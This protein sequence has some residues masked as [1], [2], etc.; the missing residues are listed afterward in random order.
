MTDKNSDNQRE[1]KDGSFGFMAVFIFALAMGVM[2]WVTSNHKEKELGTKAP[3]YMGCEKYILTPAEI[4]AISGH[5]FLDNGEIT[6]SGKYSYVE[7]NRLCHIAYDSDMGNR[8]VFSHEYGQANCADADYDA[9]QPSGC[10]IQRV[11]A[12]RVLRYSVRSSYTMVNGIT[13]YF[14][15][16]QN[17]SSEKARCAEEFILENKVVLKR[18]LFRPKN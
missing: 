4:S 3:C 6:V 12:N 2:Y 18:M 9:V 17:S 8:S 5:E 15:V 14:P 10:S 11:G 13:F 7:Q 1:S 16:E